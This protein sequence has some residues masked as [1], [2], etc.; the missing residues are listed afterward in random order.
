MF[1]PETIALIAATFLIAGMVKGLVG[2]GLPTIALAL[3]S[4]GIG[5]K[6]AIALTLV[7]A[8][9]MNIW[10]AFAGGELVNI[11]RRF[12]AWLIAICLGIW[13]GTSVL[14]SADSS[15]LTGLLGVLLVIYSAFSLATPQLPPPG[16]WE[17]WLSPLFGGAAGVM[18][19]MTGALMV[20][21]VMYIQALGMRRDL[22]VQSLGVTFLIST[23]VLLIAFRQFGLMPAS[24]GATSALALVPAVIGMAIGQQLRRRLPEERFRPVFFVVL[25]GLGLII[26]VRSLL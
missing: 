3:L 18:A 17:P 5:L 15:V 19:G 20:P 9:V 23:V 6:E 1:P 22:L 8:L 11:L 4:A 7:P 16:R 21:G 25:L 2:L 12:W 26:V 10:Q 24:L 13:F 14:V